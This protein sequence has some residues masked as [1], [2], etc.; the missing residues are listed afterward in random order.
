MKEAIEKEI[1]KKYIEAINYYELDINSNEKPYVESFINLSFIYWC[2]AFEYFEFI[3]PNGISEEFSL[4]GGDR[5]MNIIDKGIEKYP[6][7]IELQFWKKYFIHISYGEEFSYEECIG[8]LKKSKNEE[9]DVLY[10]FLY[11]FDEEKYEVEKDKLLKKIK[12]KLILKNLY[13]I[14]LLE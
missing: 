3:L 7:N 4:I 10:F 11:M 9:G 5:F 12:G 2:L 6:D 14:S 1:E 8:L 13:I